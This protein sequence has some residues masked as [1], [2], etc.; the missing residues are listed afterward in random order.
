MKRRMCTKCVNDTTVKNIHFNEEG[1]CNYCTSYDQIKNQVTD[2]ENLENNF[3]KRLEKEKGRHKYDVAVGFSGGKDSTYVLYQMVK[4]Y[5]LKVYAYTLDNVFLSE[6]AHHKIDQIVKELGVDHEYITFDHQLLQKVYRYTLSKFLSPCIACSYLGYAAMI[7]ITTAVDAAVGIHGR[8]RPQ[9]FRM[10]TCDYDDTFKP[11]IE[12]GLKDVDD[13]DFKHTYEESLR[14]I[15]KHIDKKIADY[16]ETELLKDAKTKGY[17][18]FIAYFLY[19]PYDKDEII[20]FISEHLSWSIP[21]E[22]EHFDCVIHNA[23]TYI[24][25]ITARRLHIMP[26][27]SVMIRENTLTREEALNIL[28]TPNIEKPNDELKLLCSFTKLS[29]RKLLLKASLYAKRWW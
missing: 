6:E 1:V 16:I 23:A 8:S 3:R 17:R 10:Y 24:K 14:K 20:R 29:E 19:H 7:N 27:L 2:Y 4:T 9:M 26:E 12:M 21:S 15:N 22:T 5:D 25:N 28:K 18:D 11:F 13:V